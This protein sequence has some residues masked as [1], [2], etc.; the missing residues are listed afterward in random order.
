MDMSA[1]PTNLNVRVSSINMNVYMY[2]YVVPKW[3]GCVHV[4]GHANKHFSGVKFID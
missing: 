4:R 1:D 3:P 2:M